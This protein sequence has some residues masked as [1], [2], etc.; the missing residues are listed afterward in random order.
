MKTSKIIASEILKINNIATFVLIA[1][2]PKTKGAF[3]KYFQTRSLKTIASTQQKFQKINSNYNIGLFSK[4]IA[5]DVEKHI[6]MIDFSNSLIPSYSPERVKKIL[7]ELN[8][9][10]GY[11][12]HSGRSYHFYGT[13]LITKNEWEIM[14][15]NC[16]K[17]PEI[18]EKYVRNQLRDGGCCL[19]LTTSEL[20]PKEPV[21]IEKYE[22]IAPKA[23][24]C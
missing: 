21:E 14:M 15:E 20:K 7:E 16:K 12:V 13:E 3:D 23:L 8:L 17:Y 4:V 2:V 24:F 19:R 5:D 10:A 1:Y 11:I 18:G 6:P 9:P 22:R